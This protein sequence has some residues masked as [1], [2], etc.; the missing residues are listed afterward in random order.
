[1]GLEYSWRPIRDRHRDTH[2]VIRGWPI[3]KGHS[4]TDRWVDKGVQV[5]SKPADQR[6]RLRYFPFVLKVEAQPIFMAKYVKQGVRHGI[7]PVVRVIGQSIYT[8][9]LHSLLGSGLL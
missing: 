1:M 7:L 5:I 3:Q 4:G 9:K 2:G 6:I 8:T